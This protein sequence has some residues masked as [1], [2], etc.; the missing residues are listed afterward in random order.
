MYGYGYVC[1][2]TGGA[3]AWS[4]GVRIAPLLS[5]SIQKGLAAQGADG[6]D[7]LLRE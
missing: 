3:S 1:Q 6:R 4:N 5:L 7:L 2:F